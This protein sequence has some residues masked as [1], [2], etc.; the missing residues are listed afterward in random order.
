MESH[1][2][3][4]NGRVWFKCFWNCVDIL[5]YFLFILGLIF[6]YTEKGDAIYRPH[7]ANPTGWTNWFLGISLSLRYLRAAQFFYIFELLG[8]KILMIKHMVITCIVDG[9]FVSHIL[10]G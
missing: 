4:R 1:S 7:G 6:R 8:P 2:M 10:S 9:D 5:S 3:K